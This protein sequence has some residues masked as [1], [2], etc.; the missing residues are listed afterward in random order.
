MRAAAV[1]QTEKI[2]RAATENCIVNLNEVIGI[3]RCREVDQAVSI[4]PC[5]ALP[6]PSPQQHDRA[7]AGIE[8]LC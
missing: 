6:C 8:S 4:C 7:H 5:Q 1:L 3:R 2:F